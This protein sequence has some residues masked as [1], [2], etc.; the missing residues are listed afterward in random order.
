[1]T[2]TD[3]I[4]V[5]V[6]L[7]LWAAVIWH[8]TQARAVGELWWS[9]VCL[10]V[11]ISL[12]IG[13]IAD[14]F[15]Q[16]TGGIYLD[17][18]IIHLVGVAMVTLTLSW[19]VLVRFGTRRAF[20]KSRLTASGLTLAFLVIT[21]FLAPIYDIPASSD[22][23]PA[24]VLAAP[25]MAVHWLGI[26][27]YLLAFSIAFV[28]LAWQES[29]TLPPGF[30]RLSIRFL[31]A[32]AVLF[33]LNNAAETAAQIVVL[34]TGQA[35]ST[36]LMELVNAVLMV[37]FALFLLAIAIPLARRNR[38]AAATANTD[39]RVESLWRWIQSAGT[40]QP[41]GEQNIALDDGGT[42]L[43]DQVVDIRDQ[44]WL[45]QRYIGPE[46]LAAAGRQAR[47]RGHLFGVRARAYIAA[48]CLDLAAQRRAEQTRPVPPPP[49]N[50]ARLGGGRTIDQEAHWLASVGDALA[51]RLTVSPQTSH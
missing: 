14:P 39:A 49:A 7:A 42:T 30:V 41:E 44:M 29:R 46:D 19:L 4:F 48:T 35:E 32:A 15:N 16:L 36:W 27:V 28:A 34:A 24:P 21:W 40:G 43:L 5:A 31:L 13:V 1:M 33:G 8:R 10:A 2:A 50:L 20:A 45:L 51:A 37:V 3:Y 6:A 47:A 12:K 26:N 23:I 25:D 38:T 17:E 22:W 11:I 9:C 18:L